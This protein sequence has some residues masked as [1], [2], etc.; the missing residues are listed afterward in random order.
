MGEKNPQATLGTI[1][2]DHHKK[3]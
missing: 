3:V 2:Y 1:I